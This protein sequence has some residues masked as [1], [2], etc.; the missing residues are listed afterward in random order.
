MTMRLGLDFMDHKSS[1]SR[2]VCLA[3]RAS[4][5]DQFHLCHESKDY[6]RPTWAEKDSMGTG[7][8][9]DVSS[10]AQRAAKTRF[11]FAED[12]RLM[13]LRSGCLEIRERLRRVR[14][15]PPARAKRELAPSRLL[16]QR[17][18]RRQAHREVPGLPPA[19]GRH[20][21]V[22]PRQ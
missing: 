6:I 15:D 2:P 16:H 21:H 17:F 19:S 18:A 11:A 3:I 12:Q 5:L 1:V 20:L 7:L 22:Q 9:F 4:I 14:A 13:L 10:D 8:A